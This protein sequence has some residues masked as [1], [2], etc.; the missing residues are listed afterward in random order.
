MPQND[1]QILD[2]SRAASFPINAV[3]LDSSSP[4]SA[5]GRRLASE[6]A[7]AGRA[8]KVDYAAKMKA[9]SRAIGAG[10]DAAAS[11]ARDRQQA[12]RIRVALAGD[13]HPALLTESSYVTL[14]DSV[15]SYPDVPRMVARIR[16]VTAKARA[17]QAARKTSGPGAAIMSASDTVATVATLFD[18]QDAISDTTVTMNTAMTNATTAMT[19]GLATYSPDSLTIAGVHQSNVVADTGRAEFELMIFDLFSQGYTPAFSLVGG[20]MAAT[21]PLAH[22]QFC[23][24]CW[25]AIKGAVGG[26]LKSIAVRYMRGLQT[27]AESVADAVEEELVGIGV[28][29]AYDTIL[30]VVTGA[31]VGVALFD[32]QQAT[33]QDTN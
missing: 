4:A 17:L 2:S 1:C 28:D 30:N 5:F 29:I 9:F 27:T 19:S 16:D 11:S 23:P 18:M 7:D 20:C 21:G 32:M 3:V 6:L 24:W 8:G 22:V 14:R 26:A 13:D 10:T 33:S 15:L 12:L 31:L 25:K